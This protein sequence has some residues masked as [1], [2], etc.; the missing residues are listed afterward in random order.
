V[1]RWGEEKACTGT[2]HFGDPETGMD[3]QAGKLTDANFG[4]VATPCALYL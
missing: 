2:V 1:V 3:G 4:S